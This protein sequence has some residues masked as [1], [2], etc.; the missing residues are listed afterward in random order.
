MKVY[1]R[2]E[3]PHKVFF[4]RDGKDDPG[5]YVRYGTELALDEELILKAFDLIMK[6][7]REKEEEGAFEDYY[8][9]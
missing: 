1:T 7:M 8:E 2:L 4:Q 6:R 5:F 3:E 9:K